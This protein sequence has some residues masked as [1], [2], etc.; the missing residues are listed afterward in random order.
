MRKKS[1]ISLALYLVR[2]LNMDGLVKHKKS[3]LSRID[4]AGSD[5]EDGHV[6][7]RI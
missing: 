5:S 1:H 6:T 2:E 3:V 4:P 7:A